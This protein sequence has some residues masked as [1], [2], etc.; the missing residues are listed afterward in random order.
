MSKLLIDD[1]PIQVLPKLAKEIGIN[2]AIVLQQIHYWLNTSKHKYENKSWIYN[3]YREWENQFPFW[4][5]ATIRRTISSLE[6]KD[7]LI[8]GNFNKA[9][10][11]KTKWYSIN[12]VMLESVSK[13]L[14]QNEQTI[15]SKRAN[16]VVQNEQ[17]NTID[18]T[19][20]STETTNNNK[21]PS[22]EA[23]SIRLK[24]KFNIIWEQYPTGRKNGKEKAFKSYQ[25]AVKEGVT[26]KEILR[27]LNGYKKQIK[28]QKTEIQFIKQG[29][30]WFTNKCWNDDYITSLGKTTDKPEYTYVPPEWREDFKDVGKMP[31]P[32]EEYSIDDLPF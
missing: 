12:Y 13:R 5:N 14:A 27:G 31:E 10:F 17:T 24:D 1:Y 28:L 15:S 19:E 20:T 30:T 23:D 6:K 25:K 4:S 18:Y 26:D 2:E 21:S 22:K 7:L 29:V 16:G 8:T 11:D 3:S 9:G 32:K